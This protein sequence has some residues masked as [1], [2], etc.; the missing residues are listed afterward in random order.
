MRHAAWFI[1]GALAW[2]SAEVARAQTALQELE[3]KIRTANQQGQLPG[4]QTG[5]PASV[6]PP[7][8]G[9]AVEPGYLGMLADD[10]AGGSGVRIVELTVGA[11]GEKA[12]LKAGDV[13]TAIDGKPIATMRDFEPILLSTQAGTKLTFQVL[14]DNQ[15]QQI[16]VT[17]GQRPAPGER[18]FDFGR[19]PDDPTAPPEARAAVLGVRLA[20][21]TP[22]IQRAYSLPAARGALVVDVV[23]GSP[24]AKAGVPIEAVV[25]FVDGKQIDTPSDL[26][27]LVAEAGPGKEI[28]LAYFS[29]GQ[30]VERKVRLESRFVDPLAVDPTIVARPQVESDQVQALQRRI[31]EL[32]KRVA[33]LEAALRKQQ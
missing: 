7:A 33:E 28:K 5:G 20:T 31:L 15:P 23:P 2:S 29:R 24:A 16:V 22:E 32:E 30:L 27:R 1:V 14:R 3:N 10:Q 11:P 18:R 12:G 4:Q 17:L 26:S 25:V 8:A 6:V 19:I 13:V 21:V 9:A